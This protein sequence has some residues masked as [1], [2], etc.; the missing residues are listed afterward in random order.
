[1]MMINMMMMMIPMVAMMMMMMM[2]TMVVMMIVRQFDSYMFILEH[3][4]T[5]SNKSM[6]S[7]ETRLNFSIFAEK[8]DHPGS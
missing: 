5:S 3:E 1:M 7:F 2:I 8:K 6:I 4:I